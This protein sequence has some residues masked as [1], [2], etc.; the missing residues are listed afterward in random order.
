MLIFPIIDISLN[1]MIPVLSRD[2]EDRDL[3]SSI[4]VI[5]YGI[6]TVLIE[7]LVPLLLSFYG[8]SRTSYIAIIVA[9]TLLVIILSVTGAVSLNS[10]SEHVNIVT[11]N[12]RNSVITFIRVLKNHNVLT[13]FFSGTVSTL[14][15]PCW[16]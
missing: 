6:G 5:G 2:S 10:P 8:A 3:L 12:K 9:F 14:G 13:T 15:M 11:D 16:Q 1:G 7:I 4:K